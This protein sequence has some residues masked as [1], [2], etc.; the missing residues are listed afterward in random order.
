M[1]VGSW[2]V[3]EKVPLPQQGD[4]VLPQD[5]T[6]KAALQL[7]TER[8]ELAARDLDWKMRHTAEEMVRSAWEARLRAEEGASE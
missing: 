3:R 4:E 6:G 8:G 1:A 2:L 5:E 7:T